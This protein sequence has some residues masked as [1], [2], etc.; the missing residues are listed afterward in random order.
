LTKKPDLQK[1]FGANLRAAR[2]KAGLTQATLGE[3]CGLHRSEISLLERGERE[4][5]LGTI[6]KLSSILQTTPS[7][8]C[9]GIGW[10]ER[11]RGFIVD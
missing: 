9:A 7:R 4:P 6:V 5:R 2:S 1:R 8:L 10:Q 3:R 11:S